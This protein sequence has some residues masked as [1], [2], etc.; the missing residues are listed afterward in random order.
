MT[1]REYQV[2]QDQFDN[3]R[4]SLYQAQK[5]YLSQHLASAWSRAKFKISRVKETDNHLLFAPHRVPTVSSTFINITMKLEP[6]LHDA[7]LDVHVPTFLCDPQG[8]LM[9]AMQ[10]RVLW[11]WIGDVELFPPHV[12]AKIR[13]LAVTAVLEELVEEVQAS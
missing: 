4:L 13:G 2:I 8:A 12:V 1:K 6:F 10:H 7:G 11:E 3:A 9:G 5:D